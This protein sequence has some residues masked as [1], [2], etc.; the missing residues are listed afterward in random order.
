MLSYAILTYVSY[1]LTFTSASFNWASGIIHNFTLENYT[2]IKKEIDIVYALNIN[3]R[4][5]FVSLDKAFGM[6]TDI[7]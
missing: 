2:N 1:P 5:A 6:S 3:L 7:K 4:L